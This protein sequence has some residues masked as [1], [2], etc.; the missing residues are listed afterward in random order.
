M[1]YISN[2]SSIYFIHIYTVFHKDYT[3]LNFCQHRVEVPFP[4]YAPTF[5]IHSV[6]DNSHSIN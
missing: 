6:F 4:Q 3:N 1:D 5:V 2:G